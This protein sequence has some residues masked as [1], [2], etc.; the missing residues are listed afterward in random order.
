MNEFEQKSP[1][2]YIVFQCTKCSQYTYAKTSQKGKKCPRCGRNHVVAHLEGEI[3]EGPTNAMK[4]VKQ[5]QNDT[6]RLAIFKRS[7]RSIKF[8]PK[9]QLEGTSFLTA[10]SQDPQLTK[11]LGK[12]VEWQQNENILLQEGFP[13]YVLEYI[14]QEIEPNSKRCNALIKRLVRLEKF[15]RLSSGNVYIGE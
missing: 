14:A 15:T 13:E 1:T 6:H 9:K 3:V 11:L 12:I 4:L 7:K 10:V 8:Q 2:E 5:I